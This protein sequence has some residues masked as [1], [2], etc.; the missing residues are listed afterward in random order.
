M[1]HFDICTDGAEAV[2][3]KITG[4]LTQIKTVVPNYTNILFSVPCIH[5]KK[6]NKLKKI[7]KCQFHLTLS[8]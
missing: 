1:C 2:V 4:V 5:S 7:L 8:L 3:S 6:I